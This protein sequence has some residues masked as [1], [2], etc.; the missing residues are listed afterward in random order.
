[1]SKEF[2]LVV[3]GAGSGGLAAAKRAATY[4]AKVAVLEGSKV[5]GTCVIRGCV[6]KKLLVYA[7][8]SKKNIDLSEGYGLVNK[9]ISF[10]SQTLL[11]NIKNEVSRLSDLHTKSLHKLNVE[12]INGWGRFLND[13]ELEVICPQ[14]RNVLGKVKG[15]KILISVGGTPRKLDIYGKEFAWYSDD[16]FNLH[17]FP[18]S[19]L[20]VGGGYI[21]CEFACIFNNLGTKVTQV[22]RS[23]NLLN[24]FDSDLSKSLCENM[25][26]SGI[27]ILFE[28]QLDHVIK[29][30]DSLIFH[31]KSGE[32][33]NH[34]NL[35]I[36]AGRVPNFQNLNL[37]NIGLKMNNGFIAVNDLN[38]TSKDNVFAIGDIV[39]HPSLT[40]VAIEQ[41]RVFSDNYFGGLNRK[42]SYEFVPK[43]VFTD[44]EVSSVGLSEEEAESIFSKSNIQI[45]KC[46]FNPM[47]N[48][49]KKKKS[50]CL[51]K[52]IVNKQNNRVLGCHMFG[53][54]AA[55]IIQMASIALNAGATKKEFDSTMALHPT[56]SEEFVT[57]YG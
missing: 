25:I 14:T 22:V 44:P 34:S 45:F 53:E 39:D 9:F 8:S 33:F 26:N 36:A 55:E 50:K 47:S 41:G 13:N 54:S 42:V 18:N 40:P 27:N 49:F 11:K 5:G 38:K 43:A 7:A 12:I 24:G 32:N 30:N 3:I 46:S 37:H 23:K 57:M 15:N 48:T 16:I 20:I 52:L 29:K 17:K 1:M 6:P 2:D 10:N 35:L 31:L 28:D 21:A 56:I 19:I 51:L 4:G